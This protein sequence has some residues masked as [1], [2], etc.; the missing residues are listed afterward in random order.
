MSVIAALSAPRQPG[1]LG[2]IVRGDGQTRFVPGGIRKAAQPVQEPQS[3]KHGSIDADADPMVSGL[4][5]LQSRTARKSSLG[6]HRR[7]QPTS[8]AGIADVGAKLAKR[9]S[10]RYRWP[11]RRRHNVTFVLHKW[12]LM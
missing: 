3:L 12:I 9:S 7:R 8:K 11:V 4:D 10:H 5:P 6:D 1:A 2:Q